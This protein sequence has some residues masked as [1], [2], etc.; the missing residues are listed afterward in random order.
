MPRCGVRN[1]AQRLLRMINDLLDVTKLEAQDVQLFTAPLSLAPATDQP[2]AAVREL[3]RRRGH[4]RS[5]MPSPPTCRLCW[6]TT[7]GCTRSLLNLLTNAIKFTLPGGR[8]VISA[9]PSELNADAARIGSKVARRG[10]RAAWRS[11]CRIP[12]LA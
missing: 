5:I 6:P 4:R 9:R 11:R 8:V 10:P 12:V 3:R 2:S 7:S 1:N